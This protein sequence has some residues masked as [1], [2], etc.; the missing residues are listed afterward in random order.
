M[1]ID[2]MWQ[3]VVLESEEKAILVSESGL[4]LTLGLGTSSAQNENLRPLL[5]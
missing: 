2:L 4:F 5:N 3:S 1:E